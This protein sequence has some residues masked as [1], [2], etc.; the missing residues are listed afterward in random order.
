M[1][2]S[3]SALTIGCRLSIQREAI[4][5]I[6]ITETGIQEVAALDVILAIGLL[7]IWM[8]RTVKSGIDGIG[9]HMESVFT[10][11]DGSAKVCLVSVVFLFKLCRRAMITTGNKGG[12]CAIG[13]EG[14]ING[15]IGRKDGGGER[16]SEADSSCGALHVVSLGT[17]SMGAQGC[18]L[19]SHVLQHDLLAQR[20]TAVENKSHTSRELILTHNH[21]LQ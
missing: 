15:T 10:I 19:S 5:I 17:G 11:V 12:Y 2:S 9:S 20:K 18:G 14:G 8:Q 1:D 7:G 21:I 16:L 13:I 6:A 3:Q 4:L